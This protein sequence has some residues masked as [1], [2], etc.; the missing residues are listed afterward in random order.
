MKRIFSI[1]LT[2]LLV[3]AFTSPGWAEEEFPPPGD[4]KG[5]IG[6]AGN[7]AAWRLGQINQLQMTE[8]SAPS[9]NPDTNK[10]WLYVKDSGGT[11][12]LYFEDDAGTVTDLVAT[13]LATD[14][15]LTADADAGDY[16][17]KSLDKLEF[18]DTG[19]YIDGGADATLDIVSDG[20]V[21][22]D[23]A[24][25]DI[26]DTGVITNA[27]MS[28]D[29]ISAGNLTLGNYYLSL[30]TDPADAGTIRLPNAG[31]ILFEAAPAGT[32]VNALSVDA[33]EVVQ[34]GSAGASAVTITPDTTVSGS[35]TVTGTYY[36]S[37]IAPAAGDLTL[38]AAGAGSVDIGNVST[39]TIDIT[40]GG[41]N[42]GDGAADTLTI[43]GIIDA[44][45]TLD[46]GTTD[47]P[48]LIWKD[49]DDETGRIHQDSATDDLE[50]TCHSATDSFAV[51]T[52]N[53]SVGTP[54][55]DDIT[56]NGDDFYVTDDM[57]V[58]GNAVFEA[59]VKIDSGGTGLDLNETLDIDL[60][61]NDE[62]VSI[63]STAAD[64]AAGSGIVTVYDDS[65][66]QT[67]TQY[68]V[69][70]LREANA[71]A[72]D[73]FIECADN[74]TGAANDGDTKFAVVSGGA[75]TWT[76]DAAATITVDADTTDTTDTGGVVDID[77]G[78]ATDGADAVNIKVVSATSGATEY[79]TGIEIDLD[80]DTSAA[81]YVRGINLVSTDTTG[82]S[83]IIGIQIASSIETGIKAS[84]DAAS[85]LITADATSA[86]S[87]STTG[88]LLD[89]SFRTA[90]D[91]A[92]AINID[93]ESDVTGGAGEVVEGIHIQMDDDSN[94]A[95]DE[96]RG[97]EIDTDANGTG[98]QYAIYVG[99]TAGIDAAL[100][101]ARGY[102][103]IGTGDTP[104]VTPGDDD[105]FVEG[106]VEVNGT[107]RFDN[108]AYHPPM[109]YEFT[110]EADI[111]DPITSNVVLLDGDDDADNDTIDLQDGTYPGQILY[112]VAEADI[113]ADDT[114][115]INYGDT[116]CTN[117]P[118][119]VFN[120]VGENA[121]LVWTGT[122]WSVIS[123]QD[124]L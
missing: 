26:S 43:T 51:T 100:Y 15:G 73:A 117:C 102:V 24:D 106:T 17:I 113:D 85:T 30:G 88:A 28:A 123:L 6:D 41:V 109:T 8:I 70:L 13:T 94:T 75:T 16:D 74:S 104:D 72:N 65:A 14:F 116:T 33:S 89:A 64:Y 39:G 59:N 3:F 23:S 4:N 10:G 31:N 68:L 114:C 48:A 108:L 91:T 21:S 93:L 49:S 71:D 42:I 82:S 46:D 92:Q 19:V 40:G 54:G 44:D 36:H 7:G 1:L 60:D 84:L 90:T 11:S 110:T 76:L 66:G 77:M 52:G 47:S 9:G 107:T 112:L 105:L 103:R 61:A 98:L 121:H 53:L 67:N 97:I 34:I 87:T 5:V 38:N 79:A 78:S 86:A 80:D 27:S 96:L 50:V 32:D 58:D 99:D 122:T 62:E 37:A 81:G 18:I 35:L 111:T 118:A 119:T 45:V 69:R 25:W 120:K 55:A 20:T 56:W 95:T 83:E 2:I 29:Q 115:T 22:I 57:E 12:V 101:A 124:G 63:F